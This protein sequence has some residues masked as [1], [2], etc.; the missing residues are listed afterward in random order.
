MKDVMHA[1]SQ[2]LACLLLVVTFVLVVSASVL[3]SGAFFGAMAAT[4]YK[5]FQWLI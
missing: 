5:V 1:A 2:L 3:M 4:I